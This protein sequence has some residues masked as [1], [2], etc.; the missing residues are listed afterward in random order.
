MCNVF[1][2]HWQV[3]DSFVCC[4]ENICQSDAVA[5]HCNIVRHHCDDVWVPVLC[6]GLALLAVLAAPAP[7][8]GAIVAPSLLW[9]AVG[10]VAL[11][12]TALSPS[13]VASAPSLTFWWVGCDCPFRRISAMQLGRG[14][15]LGS[16]TSIRA[17]SAAPVFQ[18][19]SL[20]AVFS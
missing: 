8:P 10:R 3:H 6:P 9:L 20:L 1:W 13:P 4:I 15:I 7:S 19:L 2:D 5:S 18:N 17:S 16:S 12:S 14:S 11:S